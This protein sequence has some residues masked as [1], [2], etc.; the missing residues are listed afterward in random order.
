MCWRWLLL[1]FSACFLH[2]VFERRPG[3]ERAHVENALQVH[4]VLDPSLLAS[5]GGQVG[6][7]DHGNPVL[8]MRRRNVLELL[9]LLRSHE[10]CVRTSTRRCGTSCS[11]PIRDSLT[12]TSAGLGSLIP[13]HLPCCPSWPRRVRS[14]EV[15][16]FLTCLHHVLH[17]GE[18]L[19][20]RRAD[21]A[22]DQQRRQ[23]DVADHGPPQQAAALVLPPNTAES[24]ER[25][26]H[27]EPGSGAKGQRV[28]G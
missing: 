26:D 3:S 19:A 13:P 24:A 5:F 9:P 21:R 2:L 6:E 10:T 27:G 25:P 16:W 4:V 7:P 17:G 28:K 12:R 8:Q 20:D 23:V 11:R 22:Q 1:W 15:S 18:A 14:L